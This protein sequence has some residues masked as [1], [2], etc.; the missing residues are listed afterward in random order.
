M[1]RR[2]YLAVV[3]ALLVFVWSTSSMAEDKIGFI[4]MKEILRNS[5]AGQKAIKNLKKLSE[6]SEKQIK[7]AEKDLVDM[8]EKLEEESSGMTASQRDEKAKIY[9]RKLRDFEL[10]IGDADEELKRQDQETTQKML[11]DILKAVQT[12]AEKEKYTM[13]LDVATQD[14]TY[15]DKEHDISRKVIEE[16]NKMK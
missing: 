2:V 8:K 13:I 5:N 4:N 11:P 6:K 14:Y 9:Y 15:Y 3:I 10:K 7:S 12:V 16:F 1:T